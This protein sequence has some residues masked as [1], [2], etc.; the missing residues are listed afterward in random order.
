[1]NVQHRT[2]TNRGGYK[3]GAMNDAMCDI[4][5]FDHCAVFDADFDPAPDFLRRTVPYL[6]HNPKSWFRTGAMGVFQ[7]NR[8]PVDAC[9]RYP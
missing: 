6:T 8:E 1:M 7:W 4:E 2:R 3:A 5:Q 9:R